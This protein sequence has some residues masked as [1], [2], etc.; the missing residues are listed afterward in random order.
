MQYALFS[1]SEKEGAIELATFLQ[2]QGLSLLATGSTAAHLRSGG[3]DVETVADFTGAPEIL[4]GRVKTLHPRLHGSLLYLRDNAE[5]QKTQQQSNLRDICVLVVNLYPFER[6]A[7]YSNDAAQI[8]ENIDIGGPAMLRSAAK[9][10]QSVSVL[11]QPQD[12][13]NF[14]EEWQRED[15]ISLETR[16]HLA[17]KAY[18]HT[19]CYDALIS[20]Y[21]NAQNGERFPEKLAIAAERKQLARYGENPHQA[22]AIYETPNRGEN[23]LT[24][25]KQLHGKEMSFN[26]FLDAEAALNFIRMFTQKAAIII[27]HQNPCG[28]AIERPT[29]SENTEETLV[30]IY[31]RAFACDT[32]SAFGGIVAFNRAVDLPL[33]Q[34]L[35]QTFYEIVLAPAYSTDALKALKTKKNLRILQLS[36]PNAGLNL[37][38]YDLRSLRGGF[39]IQNRDES[40]EPQNEE[41]ETAGFRCVSEAKP[42]ER[43][44][45]ELLFAWKLASKVKS[46]AIVL[47]KDFAAPGIG[48]GQMSRV[49]SVR[50]AAQKM[51]NMGFSLTGSYLASDAFFPFPDAV[52]LAASYGVKAIIQPGGS[53]RDEQVIQAANQH[54]LIM[55]CT[56]TR[57]FYH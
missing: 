26:N 42:T 28:S 45:Q 1:L 8:I 6:A 2:E 41:S 32:V 54:S 49:D 31:E 38:N 19:A 51:Q 48:A 21:F 15:T 50:L 17:A 10:Y 9:N 18:G 46:N 47:S 40:L 52:E 29:N 22:A 43:D 3:L 27:K 30:N 34:K 14:I 44:V 20:G 53:V 35:S 39:A 13:K 16:S 33:A 36:G 24:H 4:G 57:H 37:P 11:C 23:L 5:H 7:S 12:Y 25:S 56:G 55:L